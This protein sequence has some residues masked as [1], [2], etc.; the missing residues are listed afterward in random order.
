MGSQVI[1]RVRNKEYL[2]YV[3]YDDKERKEFYCGVVGDSKAEQK[4]R[5][6]EIKELQLQKER[7]IVKIKEL[8]SK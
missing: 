2:Y 8:K 1:R 5:E 7:I 6:S 4:A 3:Y